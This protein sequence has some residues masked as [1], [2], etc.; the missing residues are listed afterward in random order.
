MNDKIVTH[1]ALLI[2]SFF[3]V[4][5]LLSQIDFVSENQLKS[6]S[7]ESEKKLGELVLKTIITSNE[8]IKDEKISAILDSI[9]IRICRTKAVDCSKIKLHLIRNSEVNAF[10]LPDNNIVI[11]SGL[12]EYAKNPEEVAGV[13]AH[14]IGH[15]EKNHVMKKLAKEIGLG[16]LFSIAGGDAGFEITR[17]ATKVLSSTAFDRNHEREADEFAVESLAT[18]NVDPQH[19]SNFFFR[20]ALTQNIP[21]EFAWI[22][23]HPDTKGRAANII[24]KK[25]EYTINSTPILTTP[26]EEV[27]KMLAPKEIDVSIGDSNEEKN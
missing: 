12:I 6:F 27:Q 15:I 11:Y 10:A 2:I 16:M 20:L 22:S 24:E 18:V 4:W 7:R 19:L 5:F 23:T 14:E 17:E 13:M 3:G 1:F 9:K 26:W 25:K 8:K 21:E